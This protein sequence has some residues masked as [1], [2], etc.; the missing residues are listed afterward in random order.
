M[1]SEEISLG[2][3]RAVSHRDMA[4]QR[5]GQPG[6]KE[7]RPVRTDN[8][9]VMRLSTEELVRL[10]PRLKSYLRTSAPSWPEIIEAADWLRY[11]LGVSKTLWGAACIAMGREEAAI[12]L[13][14]VSAKPA[15]HFRSN[16][17]GYFFGMIAKAKAGELNL[18][19]TVWGLRTGHGRKGT[20]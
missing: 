1:A 14:I 5:E 18:A 11:D 3:A 12:A 16:P 8:G 20:Q 10:A 9:T 13:A 6:T 19:R 7:A 15:E 17:G 2:A 4:E